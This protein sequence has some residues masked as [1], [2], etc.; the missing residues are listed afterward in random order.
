M[1]YP[2]TAVCVKTYGSLI[3]GWVLYMAPSQ[4]RSGWYYMGSWLNTLP[5]IDTGPV[6]TGL[7][8]ARYVAIA[9]QGNIG[10]SANW[11]LACSLDTNKL[12]DL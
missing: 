9:D 7:K 3:E 12:T 4:A 5:G 6:V 11:A 1:A 8:V 10:R 2:S